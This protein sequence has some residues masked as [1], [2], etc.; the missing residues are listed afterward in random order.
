MKSTK[1]LF[2]LFLLIYTFSSK[3]Q[4]TYKIHQL[5][6]SL[7][8]PYL[9]DGLD[10]F[11]AQAEEDIPLFKQGFG[12]ISVTNFNYVSSGPSAIID[13]KT[14]TVQKRSL[15]S[16]TILLGVVSYPIRL[17]P[18][19]AFLPYYEEWNYPIFYMEYKN[20]LILF[21]NDDM[22]YFLN[23]NYDKESVIHIQKLVAKTLQKT[24]EE[25]FTFKDI[26]GRY[27]KLDAKQRATMNCEQ[28]MNEGAFTLSEP[29]LIN[30]N[31]DGTV[32]VEKKS[33]K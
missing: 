3:A 13:L 20:R 1:I 6:S 19:D 8:S 23:K 2:V 9:R 27:F 31:N 17:K 7:I 25:D 12:Y 10:K 32:Y 22:R 14:N 5:D 16:N 4:T 21:H 15:L 24:E 26:L 18:D 29:Y 28:L 33:T 30:I 11:I